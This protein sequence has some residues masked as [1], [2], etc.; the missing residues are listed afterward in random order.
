MESFLCALWRPLRHAMGGDGPPQ[1]P[2][3]K[4]SEMVQNYTCNFV[5]KR[6]LRVLAIFG[7]YYTLD[8]HFKYG[9]KLFGLILN[10]LLYTMDNII[11]LH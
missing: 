4:K 7:K 5:K 11:L 1:V 6:H 3:C 10:D 2:L 9:F 8:K